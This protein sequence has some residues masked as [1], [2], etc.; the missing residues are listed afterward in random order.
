MKKKKKKESPQLSLSLVMTVMDTISLCNQRAEMV[1]IS[2]F[3]ILSLLFVESVVL[4]TSLCKNVIVRNVII[5]FSCPKS[6]SDH[7]QG[8]SIYKVCK[9][10]RT[11]LGAEG[12]ICTNILQLRVMKS[13]G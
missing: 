1:Q 5:I 8:F 9:L 11:T 10:S 7:S 3:R 4:L 2:G 6:V 13:S 12:H